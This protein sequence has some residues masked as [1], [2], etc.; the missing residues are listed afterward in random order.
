MPRYQSY[1]SQQFYNQHLIVQRCLQQNWYGK[2][3]QDKNSHKINFSKHDMKL[4]I[5]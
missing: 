5:M 3:Q 4:S 2:L 1:H